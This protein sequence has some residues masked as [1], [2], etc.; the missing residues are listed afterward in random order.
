MS[1]QVDVLMDNRHALNVDCPVTKATGT[2]KRD[3]A[4]AMAAAIPG[5]HQKTIGAGKN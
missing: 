5:S 2:E 3:N 1:G 4:K